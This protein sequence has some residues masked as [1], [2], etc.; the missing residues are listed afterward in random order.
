MEPG[1]IAFCFEKANLKTIEKP[2]LVF[3]NMLCNT[4]LQQNKV[5]KK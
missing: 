2:E 4:T 5:L 1:N 3:N